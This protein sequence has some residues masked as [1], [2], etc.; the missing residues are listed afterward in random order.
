[1]EGLCSQTEARW[2]YAFYSKVYER[3]Q[4]YFTSSEMREAGLDLAAVAAGMDVLDVGAGTGTLS[5]QVVGRGVS[6]DRLTLID[7][8]EGMLSQARAKP[9]LAGA[10]TVLADAHTLPFGAESF[11]R[12]V[13][14]GAIY[15]FPQP[16]LAL[17]E[18]MRVVR[19][20]GVVLAMG[21]LQPKPLLLRLLAT[22]FNR[23]PTEEEYVGWFEEAGLRDDGAVLPP[24][25]P[26]CVRKPRGSW[27]RLPLA[28]ARFSVA[29]GAFAILGP[30]QAS[31]Q[32]PG[33][34]R[35]G[36]C[37]AHAPPTPRQVLNA[38]VGMR[39][40]RLAQ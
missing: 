22:T 26:L 30:L 16:V 15:Y 9:E 13:S 8:S 18:Q 12:V 10:T 2:F 35:G 19:R 34:R 5:M 28:V 36:A 39:R 32:A 6:P 20:G 31:R 38:A 3:L 23:F 29:M 27:W 25:D 21:S 40:L 1:M 11:D 14:S 37:T 24:A 17:R 7:Q 33:P 4:P